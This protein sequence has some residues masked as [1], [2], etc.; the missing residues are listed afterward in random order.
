MP[1]TAP[2]PATTRGATTSCC[3]SPPTACARTRS[4]SYADQGVVPGFRKLLRDGARASGHGLLTQA[5]PNTGAGWFTLATGA[6]PGVHG[7]TNNTF[8]VNGAAVRHQH[9]GVRHAPVAALPDG[10]RGAPGRD[11]GPIGR[12]RRQARRPDRMG[13]RA[14]R[15]HQRADA[16][17]PRLQVGPR[18][19]DQLH[20]AGRPPAVR[21]V[22]RPAVR[23]PGRVCRPGAVPRRGP[24]ARRRLDRRAAELQ[25]RAGDAPARHRRPR[26]HRHRQVRAQRLHLR[27]PQR[28]QDGLR[29]RPLL[30]HQGR[31]RLRR[32]PQGG[33]ARRR[34]GQ[35]RR[36]QRA[37]GQ[38]RRHAGQGRAARPRPLT[39]PALPHLGVARQCDVGE[40]AGRAGLHRL[41]RGLRQ[42]ALRRVAGRRLRG[43]RVRDRQRGDLRAAGRLLGDAPTTR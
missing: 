32:R 37:A 3:S 17:L 14:R 31:R 43:P 22:V 42:R 12:T 11:A 13:R 39:G 29:P 15:R 18:R 33:S 38:D 30:A 20:R 16:R 21:R 19:G 1:A 8:H 36:R 10:D 6:W 23:P 41:V 27:Q 40:L 25:P 24:V 9:G 35:D 26:R 2:S 5:P 28:R 4:R 34:Q 7:S